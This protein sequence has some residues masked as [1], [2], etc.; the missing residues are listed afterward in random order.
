MPRNVKSRAARP[1]TRTLLRAVEYACWVAGGLAVFW[2]VLVC[3]ERASFQAGAAA[4]LAS[5]PEINTAEPLHSGDLVGT[6]SVPRVGISAIIAEGADEATLRRAVGH[7]PGT[8]RPGM[9]GTLALAA[10]RDTFFRPLRRIRIGDSIVVGTGRQEYTYRVVRTL[11]VSP[12][13]VGVLK[14]SSG[15]DLALVTC[16]PFDYIGPAPKRFIVQAVQVAPDE[17]SEHAVM[18]SAKPIGK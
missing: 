15:S 9:P 3:Y 14:P 18:P 5:L 6:I 4:D 13:Q 10:H 12:N 7:V 1:Y 17:A 11:V 16:F 8:A 2:F